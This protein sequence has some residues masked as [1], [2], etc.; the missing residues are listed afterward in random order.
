MEEI[1]KPAPEPA[2]PLGRYRVLSST[3]GIRVS[4]LQLGAMSIGDSWSQFMGSMNKEQSFAL[5]D[6]FAAA[7]GNFIDTANNY[8]NEQ[9]EAWIGEWMA[10]RQNR[11][12]MVI[13]TKFTTDYRSH[14]LGK[15]KVPNACGNHKRS[16]I[17]SVR[18]SLRKLQTDFIDVLYLHWWDHTTSIEEV[19]DSLHILVEQGKV[20]YLGISDSPA[21]VVSAAN[22]YARAHGKTPFS[23]YQ[24]RWNVMRRD[25]ERDILPMARHFGMALAP[26]D[27]LGSGHFQSAK[28]IEARKKSGEGLRNIFGSEQTEEEKRIS[29]AL[30]T[31]AAE[32]GIE[33]V[34][35]IAL[36]Y[37]LC[38]APNVFPLVGGRKIEHLH[39]NIQALTIRLT[40]K[41]IEFLEAATD[42]DVG[43]PNNFI[44]I[45]PKVTGG[46]QNMLMSTAGHID[47]VQAPRAV[48]YEPTK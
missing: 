18:D 36:A 24:G 3:A 21:W 34:T 40:D 1:F 9:S 12:Q 48:G 31:V 30:A 29:E 32:H 20:M 46:Q 33:S 39:D 2:T 19:M 28:Q 38:K 43:F 17:L 5:L 14:A 26:W 22:T 37:V 7:G 44:G 23:V 4:P 47:Y 45:D 8:Q 11:D 15:G 16:M 6:A 41:Q 13:A 35:A 10:A 25:F 42:F 27:V